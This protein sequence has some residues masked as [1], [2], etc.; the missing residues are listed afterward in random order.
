MAATP[1]SNDALS[2]QRMQEK[3]EDDFEGPSSLAYDPSYKTL[4]Y[5]LTKV[6]RE[7]TTLETKKRNWLGEKKKLDA[8]SK[9]L[10]EENGKLQTRNIDLDW[11]KS[12]LEDEIRRLGQHVATLQHGQ[13]ETHQY[14]QNEIQRAKADAQRQET[15]YNERI[16]QLEKEKSEQAAN[17]LDTQSAAKVLMEQNKSS[18]LSDSEIERWF[19]GKE[20]AW[21]G[22][23]KDFTNTNLSRL[24]DISAAALKGLAK[25]V[26]LDGRLPAELLAEKRAPYILLHGLV[27]SFICQEA[28]SSPWWVFDAIDDFAPKPPSRNPAS[29]DDNE[30]ES[31]GNPTSVHPLEAPEMREQMDTLYSLLRD[32]NEKESDQWRAH[33][34]RILC[35]NG[36]GKL[37]REP[38]KDSGQY[39]LS[40]GRERF[41]QKLARRFM[42][43]TAAQFLLKPQAHEQAQRRLEEELNSA[44]E[45]SAQLWC[46]RLLMR[47]AKSLPVLQHHQQDVLKAPSKWLQPHQSQKETLNPPEMF[48]GL[49]LLVVVH[50][51]VTVRGTEEGQ[52]YS[53]TSRIWLKARAWMGG[54]NE[55]RREHEAQRLDHGLM[56]WF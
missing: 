15:E 16:I 25:F 39:K 8:Q 37:R 36:L 1:N 3:Q 35:E 52:N 47:T 46:G 42:S 17:V 54:T 31:Q 50:P 10:V 7:K 6:S 23:A 41:A 44:L 56:D 34:M 29:D 14:W 19:V 21:Y 33:L 38:E 48:N 43:G 11:K 13:A 28:F 9:R 26:A 49:P 27:A 24:A 55:R 12:K 30:V 45:Y 51:A 22:W 2:S 20:E 18:A 4:Q 53:A 40:K 5:C 32:V